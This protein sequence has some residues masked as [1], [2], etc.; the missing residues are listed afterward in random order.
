MLGSERA[1]KEMDRSGRGREKTDAEWCFKLMRTCGTILDLFQV[2]SKAIHYFLE[3]TLHLNLLEDK[4][5]IPCAAQYILVVYL[6]YSCRF[7][8]M[9]PIPLIC[10]SPP[11]LCSLVTAS[12]CSTSVSLLLFCIY[13]CLFVCIFQIPHVSGITWSLFFSVWLHSVWSSPGPTMLLQMA[14]FHSFLWLSS[15]PLCRWTTFSLSIALLMDTQV[16]CTSWLL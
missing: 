12:L 3:I 13:V 1:G 6:F 15:I 2:Y 8:P 14:R 9:N 16:V 10:P 7:V 5:I 4:A 11:S